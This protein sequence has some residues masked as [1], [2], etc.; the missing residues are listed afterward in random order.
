GEDRAALKDKL[1]ALGIVDAHAEDIAGQHVGGELNSI[2]ASL[3]ALGDG[4]GQYRLAHAGDILQQ[5]MP[6]RQQCDDDLPHRLRLPEKD[7]FDLF[8]QLAEFFH[9][10]TIF[11]SHLRI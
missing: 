4:A 7:R 2:E 3:D 6:P 1:P 10:Y 5:H 11:Y 8:N 9:L